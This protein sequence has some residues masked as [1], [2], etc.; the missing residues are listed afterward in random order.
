MRFGKGYH[1]LVN[2]SLDTPPLISITLLC[3]ASLH[4]VFAAPVSSQDK[5]TPLHLAAHKGHAEVAKALLAA[6]ANVHAMDKVSERRRRRGG[7][8]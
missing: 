1:L 4:V 3:C 7:G 6:G 8:G 5:S 2:L